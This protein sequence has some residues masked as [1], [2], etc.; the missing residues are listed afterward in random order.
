[1]ALLARILAPHLSGA[2]MEDSGQ[3]V[4]LPAAEDTLVEKAAPK[5]RREF[6]LGR[7]CARAALRGLGHGDAVVG[8]NANGAPV[9]PHGIIGSITHTAGYAAALVGEAR[10]FSGIGLDAE[11]VG[12]VTQDLWPRLF[13]ARERDHLMSLDD[14]DQPI[15]ATL[16]FSAKEA[17]YKA[18][19][20]AGTLA[21]RDIHV[22]PDKDGFTAVR[23]RERLQG[24]H[25]VAAD[26]MLTA[27]WF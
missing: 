27:V 26:L 6:A 12:G 17:C 10:H 9:W 18:W 11:R 20:G 19:G 4:F 24:R 16:I 2:E 15:V 21:F 7:A 1:M 14:V 8:K 3:P 22:T 5:R 25:V 13:T 23:R